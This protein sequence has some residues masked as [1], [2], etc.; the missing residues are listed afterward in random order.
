MTQADAHEGPVQ[1][2]DFE[3]VARETAAIHT[4]S[5]SMYHVLLDQQGR[6][7]LRADNV[8]NPLSRALDRNQWWRIQRPYPWPPELGSPVRLAAP[9][10]MDRGDRARIPGGGKITSPVRA[11]RRPS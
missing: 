10:E 2:R 11:V 6:W 8:P 9:P 7:W 3:V 5:G 4:D 1:A